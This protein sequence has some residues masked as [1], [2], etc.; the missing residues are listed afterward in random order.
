M[1]VIP[2]RSVGVYPVAPS[3]SR[4]FPGSARSS[5]LKALMQG[6]QMAS[7]TGNEKL[8]RAASS[9]MSFRLLRFERPLVV[10]LPN[11]VPFDH[12]VDCMPWRLKVQP[13]TTDAMTS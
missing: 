11:V 1:S 7:T 3:S 4:S 9:A 10:S 2:A 6:C 13:S 5:E 12:V 8:H